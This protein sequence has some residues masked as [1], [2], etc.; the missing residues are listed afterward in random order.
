MAGALHVIERGLEGAAKIRQ[1]PGHLAR[2]PGLESEQIGHD[3]GARL[4][5]EQGAQL[6]EQIRR[7]MRIGGLA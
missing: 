6:E 3:F 2:M 1:P 5:P 4:Q 7:L